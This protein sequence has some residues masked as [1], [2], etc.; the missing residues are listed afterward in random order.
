M[1]REGDFIFF[2]LKVK[3]LSAAAFLGGGSG[4]LVLEAAFVVEP[5]RGRPQNTYQ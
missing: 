4:A 2:P 1:K 5:Q 3:S